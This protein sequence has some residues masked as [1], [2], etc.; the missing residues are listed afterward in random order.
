MGQRP[1]SV[2]YILITP[3]R[4]EEANIEKTIR[5]VISQT[6]LPKKWVILSDG[7]TDRTDEIVNNKSSAFFTKWSIAT[8][9]YRFPS[10]SILRL[11]HGV[12]W[13]SLQA[14]PCLQGSWCSFIIL[15]SLKKSQNSNDRCNISGSISGS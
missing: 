11:L 6:L 8:L 4:N 13:Q 9:S 14:V 5:S 10:Y 15:F 1:D 2:S 3:A 12:G 7:S